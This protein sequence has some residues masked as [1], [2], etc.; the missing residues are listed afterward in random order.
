ML[1]AMVPF[2]TMAQKRSKKGTNPKTEK[3]DKSS[4]EKPNFMIIKGVE[5]DMNKVGM[6]VT[7]TDPRDIGLEKDGDDYARLKADDVALERIMK[8][9]LKPLSKFSFSFD[10]GKS[11]EES[12][13]LTKA[14]KGFRS[15]TE[16]V[17]QAAIYGWEFINSTIVVDGNI[18]IHYYYMKR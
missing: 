15:M 13:D 12:L 16:A 17:N 11:T 6:E 8:Q 3:K 5:L 7:Q 10:V 14:S 18:T 9:H 1:V 4:N 2:M